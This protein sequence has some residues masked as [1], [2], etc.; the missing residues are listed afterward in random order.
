MKIKCAI[1]DD[2]F[3]ARQYLKDYI[4]KVPFLELV[5]DFNSPLKVI[6]LL[7]TNNLDLLFLDIQMPDISGLE[8]IK[9]LD[10][11]PYIILTTAYK[12]YAL[13]GYELNVTDYLL[14]PFPF[15]RFVKAVNKV[16]EQIR[17]NKL[18]ADVND[19]NMTLTQ[20]EDDFITIRADRKY[21]KINYNDLIYI[22]G[23][24]AYVTFY[25]T[26]DTITALASFKK[27]EEK[28]PANQFIRIHKSYIV[29]IKQI[30]TIE[31]NSVE[32]AKKILPIGK[33]YRKKLEEKFKMR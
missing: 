24:K 8:F 9:T 1:I 19:K 18:S 29:S 14:K 10:R 23:Q 21:Y 6:D 20:L 25:T 4:S 27:L 2:E 22:K 15:N 13:E 3:L 33:S 31:G 17:K 7:N 32:I 28:L 11:Q 12:E 30:H 16:A 5:G 26:K